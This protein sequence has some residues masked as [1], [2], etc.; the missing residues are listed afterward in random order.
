MRNQFDDS[1]QISQD[2][3]GQ[4]CGSGKISAGG[5]A[6][7]LFAL[8]VAVFIFS[9]AMC[10]YLIEQSRDIEPLPT[11]A[12]KINPLEYEVNVPPTQPITQVEDD[13]YGLELQ[14]PESSYDSPIINILLLGVEQE[15]NDTLILCSVN[16]AERS[17]AM[18]SVP[19]DT[20][21]AGDY[22]VPKVKNIYSAYEPAKRIGAVQDAVRGMFGFAADYYFVL[23]QATLTQSLSL[24]QGLS[25]QVPETPDYHSLKSGNQTLD[26]KTAF[27]LFRFKESW[28]DVETDPARVQRTFLL[29]LLDA[30]LEDKTRI[31]EICVKLSEIADTDLTVE[32]LAYLGYLLADFDFEGAYNRALPGGEKEIEKETFY[33]VDP[34]KAVEMLNEHF[35]PLKK[36]LTVYTVNFRQEQGASG[37]GQYSDYGFPSSTTEETTTESSDGE[38]DPDGSDDPNGSESTGETD[39]TEAT[40]PTEEPEPTEETDPPTETEETEAPA[41]TGDSDNGTT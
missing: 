27:E 17:L 22:E 9:V 2:D 29:R 26:G 15:I 13:P 38:T 16:L 24:I 37:D 35:N 21:V 11:E 41:E 8:S 30:L 40:D 18:L 36:E 39:S 25:F 5:R 3:E 12:V 6:I 20:Y 7:V 4:D 1:S 19:R 14:K 10:L 34:E 28:T 32:E 23:D 33:E 31:S